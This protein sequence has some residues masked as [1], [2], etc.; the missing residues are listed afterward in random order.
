[1]RKRIAADHAN[2][3]GR[4]CL[5]KQTWLVPMSKLGNEDFGNLSSCVRALNKSRRMLSL[6][7]HGN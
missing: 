1:M 4:T 7:S 6:C 2:W 5:A 3:Y